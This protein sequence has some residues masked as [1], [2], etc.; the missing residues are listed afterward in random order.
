MK[1]MGFVRTLQERD[2]FDAYPFAFVKILKVKAN[3][4]ATLTEM[5]LNSV[6]NLP[7][8]SIKSRQFF[9]HKMIFFSWRINIF[10]DLH[11]FTLVS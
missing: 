10:T 7:K 3:E 6:K 2:D 5:S 11:I 1:L 8:I 9:F 4:T